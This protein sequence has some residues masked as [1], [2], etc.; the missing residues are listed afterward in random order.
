MNNKKEIISEINNN[1]I[2]A[3]PTDTVFALVAKLK[4]E[5][6]S[7]INSLKGREKDQPVQILFSSIKEAT[8]AFEEDYFVMNYLANNN[9]EKTSYLLRAKDDFNNKYLTKEYKR[10]VLIRIP[11]GEI[12]D[13]LKEVGPLLATSANKHNE[14]PLTNNDEIKKQFNILVS[15]L[16]QKENKS[17][18]IISIIDQEVKEIR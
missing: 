5:N 17:S 4:K 10:K 7:K 16:K 13:V 9:K 11:K 3:F 8:V 18:S 15:D 2:V 12:L 1:K 6:I 14:H